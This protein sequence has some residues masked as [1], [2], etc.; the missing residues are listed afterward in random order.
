MDV[1][2]LTLNRL[3]I[4][5]RCLRALQQDGVRSVSS[6]ALAEKLLECGFDVDLPW[7]RQVG[8]S[9]PTGHHP[10]QEDD[11]SLQP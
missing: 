2:P 6:K 3:S 4:Y 11:E 1:S 10:S 5:L 9:G 7:V 8:V